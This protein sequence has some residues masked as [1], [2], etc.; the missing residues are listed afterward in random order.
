MLLG[1]PA[2]IT[3]TSAT[4]STIAASTATTSAFTP[5]FATSFAVRLTS[6]AALRLVAIR[7]GA[8]GVLVITLHVFQEVG[9]VK[10]R[11]ALQAYVDERRLHARKHACDFA[12]VN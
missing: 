1:T 9:D 10:E 8:Y 2:A 5:T 7:R 4:A 11:I 6:L 12:F 3:I